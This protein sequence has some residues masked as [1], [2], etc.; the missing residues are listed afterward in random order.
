[1][2]RLSKGM[3]LQSDPTIIYG[4]VGGKGSLGH[5]I[6]KD[7]LAKPTPYNTYLID[8]L[9][10]GPI[11][12]P[13][14]AALEA[15][16]SPSRTKELYF[17]ADGTGGHVFAETL[18]QHNRNVA[19]WRQIEAERA[20]AASGAAASPP[21]GG[22][23][24]AGGA[25]GAPGSPQPPAAAPSPS[26]PPLRFGAPGSP[27]PAGSPP[28]PAPTLLGSPGAAPAA[29]PPSPAPPAP[30]AK[31]KQKRGAK[32]PAANVK[33]IPDDASALVEPDGPVKGGGL[34]TYPL[35]PAMRAKLAKDAAAAG[36]KLSPTAP[37][38]PNVI[39]DPAAGADAADPAPSQPPAAAPATPGTPRRLGG[40]DAVAGTA[41]DPLNNKTFDLNSPK[42][43]PNLK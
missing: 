40:F 39:I 23:P 4:L 38:D 18:E 14:R 22:A 21:P 43:V 16:A 3:R 35:S 6:T 13:G 19:R 10:P 28:A 27:S 31:G 29:L 33:G 17:V 5:G 11:A 30:T 7:E 41:K 34:A 20:A 32:A 26:A 12:N 25:A 36:V 9:P 8:G 2:N 37:L 42:T 24:T 1:M 15:V